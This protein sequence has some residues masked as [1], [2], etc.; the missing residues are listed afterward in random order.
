VAI[1]AYAPVHIEICSVVNAY[2][3]YRAR[4]VYI[5]LH[6]QLRLGISINIIQAI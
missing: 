3:Y 4:S 2:T 6:N 1:N 5:A